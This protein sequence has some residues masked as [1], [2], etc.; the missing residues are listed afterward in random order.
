MKIDIAWTTAASEG[1]AVADVVARLASSGTHRPDW[2]VTYA[3]ASYNIEVLA[4]HLEAALGNAAQHGSTSSLGVMTSAGFH[5]A[6]GIGLGVFAVSDPGGAYGVGMARIGDDARAAGAQAIRRAI[7]QS[8][9]VGELPTIVWLSSAPGQEEAILAGIKDVV[10]NEV[11]I[12]GGSAADNDVSGNWRVFTG[13]EVQSDAVLVSALYPS[14]RTHF[15]F[16]NGYSPTSRRGIVTAARGR[17]LIAID[18]RPAVEVYNEWTSRLLAG[19]G[20]GAKILSDTA[21]HPLGRIAA[22]EGEAKL[23]ILSHPASIEADGALALFSAVEPGDEIIQMQGTA[24]GLVRR[25]PRVVR[26]ALNDGNIGADE[27]AGMLIVFCAGCML[28]M[29]DSMDRVVEGIRKESGNVPFLGAFTFGEQGCFVDGVSRHGNLMVSA[30]VF[31][32]DDQR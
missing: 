31:E 8:G 1:E 6:D 12:A 27:A 25:A 4:G 26:A 2:L 10:G 20:E 21:F 19:R 16:H 28:S 14:T 32:R 23:H 15:A 22:E 7:E 29:T 9:R 30:L 24:E 5:S 11:V 13:R 18:D 17:T 3:S